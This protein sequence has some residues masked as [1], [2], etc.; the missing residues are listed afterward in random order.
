VLSDAIS[1]VTLVPD[2]FT[3]YPLGVRA[4]QIP[5][6]I[7]NNAFLGMFGKSERVTAC[8]CERNGEVT[9]PQLLHL[10]N[11]DEILKKF[12]ADKGRLHERIKAKVADEE[13][14]KELFLASLT[15]LPSDKEMQT[16]KKLLSED[17]SREAVFAD[18]LWALLNSKDFA[19]NH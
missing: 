13:L 15:R 9:L 19:F 17:E 11:G 7:T 8:A 4:I 12:K 5:D 16:I 2:Q 1:Q 3:G 14:A 18:L 10:Q 6:A